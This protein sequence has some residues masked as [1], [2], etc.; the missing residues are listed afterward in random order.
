M[1][2]PPRCS[3]KASTGGNRLRFS[4]LREL[5]LPA[6]S[7]ATG[8][9]FSPPRSA[10]TLGKSG[11]LRSR[12]GQRLRPEER[13]AV[14]RCVPFRSAPRR[15]GQGSTAPP[16]GPTAP[17]GAPEPRGEAAAGPAQNIVSFISKGGT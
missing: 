15:A 1:F 6:S 14:S 2:R 7:V 4:P 5:F 8:K 11:R 16:L 9:L 10:L 3:V 13:G 12:P 17:K